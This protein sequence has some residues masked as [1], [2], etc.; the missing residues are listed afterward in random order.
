M[1]DRQIALLVLDYGSPASIEEVA[2]YYTHIRRGRPPDP[3]ALAELVGRYEAIGGISPLRARTEAQATTLAEACEAAEAGRYELVV[4][5]KH[6]PP[7]IEDAV[8]D[9]AAGGLRRVVAVVMAPHYSVGSVGQYLERARTAADA[10]GIELVA[11]EHWYDLPEYAGFL[12][13]AVTEALAG[14]PEHTQVVFT[15]HSLPARVLVGDP[16]PDQLTAGAELVARAAGLD[17]GEDGARRPFPWRIAWQSAGR[18]PEPWAGPDVTDVIAETAESPQAEGVLVVPHGFVADHLEVRY[19]LD[20]EAAASA[21]EV[22]LAF[23]RTR[24]LGDDRRVLGALADRARATAHA[25][26]DR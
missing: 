11:V 25:A 18:T 17:G 2:S 14:L 8:A 21:A 26:W 23:A 19:D 7:F 10:T 6:A 20:I 5:H 3:D 16:Y 9:I 24:V 12:A 13:G 1:S 4:G 15:A 22:G